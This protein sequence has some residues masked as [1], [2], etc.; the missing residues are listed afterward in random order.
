[1]DGLCGSGVITNA[2]AGITL[3]MR[4]QAQNV[5]TGRIHGALNVA[6]VAE[7]PVDACLVIGDA[8]TLKYTDLSVVETERHP[9]PLKFKPGIGVFYART[10]PKGKRF[11]DTNGNEVE[12]RN[13]ANHLYV[14]CSAK[15]LIRY[16]HGRFM[17][18][19]T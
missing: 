7:A 3:Q 18:V 9:N 2:K 11:F 10:F 1:M 17:D 16:A 4:A 14:N 8:D 19:I 12:L 6:P 15:M 13:Y 5:F